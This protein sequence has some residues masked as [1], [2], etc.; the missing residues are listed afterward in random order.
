MN[1][2]ME[3]G[4]TNDDMG[5][6]KTTETNMGADST[7]D[8]K[9]LAEAVRKVALGYAF[10]HLDLNLGTIDVLPSWVGYWFILSSITVLGEREESVKLLKPLEKLLII[11][12]LVTWVCR[13]FGVSLNVYM[14]DMIPAV[15]DLYFH[16]QLLTN[17]A[18]L[19]EDFGY[20]KVHHILKLRTVR[21]LISTGLVLGLHFIKDGVFLTGAALV[22]LFVC[23]WIW[24][25]LRGLYQYL[26]AYEEV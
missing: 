22:G 23:V 3:N 21:T 7:T 18:H 8:A 12:N 16:F 6:A 14:L 2:K 9:K 15:I 25:M 10:I 20:P 1:R 26:A 5:I 13:I 17:V 4:M 11:W 19:A 24:V